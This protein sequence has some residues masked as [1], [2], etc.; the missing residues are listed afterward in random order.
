MRGL[1]ISLKE[2]FIVGGILAGYSVSY[3]EVDAVGGWRWV[4]GAAVALAAV[5]A[6][7]MVRLSCFGG[8][9]V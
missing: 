1:F 6:A 3:L 7:G 9:G 2:A 5:L 4:Y 8:G